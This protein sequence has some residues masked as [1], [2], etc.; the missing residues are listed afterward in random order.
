MLEHRFRNRKVHRYNDKCTEVILTGDIKNLPPDH[1]MPYDWMK[2]QS[3]VKAEYS[4]LGLRFK[5]SGK[6]IRSDEDVDDP[7][8]AER[9]AEGRAKRELYFFLAKLSVLI[10]SKMHKE[11]HKMEDAFE[12]YDF[13]GVRECNH[14]SE[15]LSE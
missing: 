4:Y 12:K 14:L 15:L 1:Y 5:V 2:K 10:K 6:A 8:L 9:L 11:I 7:V 13:L 3:K